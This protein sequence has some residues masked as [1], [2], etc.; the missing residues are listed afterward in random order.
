[1]LLDY[2]SVTEQTK[3]PSHPLLVVA[4]MAPVPLP[5]KPLVFLED[6]TGFRAFPALGVSDNLLDTLSGVGS[7]QGAESANRKGHIAEICTRRS[8]LLSKVYLSWRGPTA[9]Q[10][11]WR[12]WKPISLHQVGTMV[13]GSG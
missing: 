11:T 3:I 1:M 12:A 13:L 6:A 7:V 9:L 8:R 2:E 5:L 4:I 10:K